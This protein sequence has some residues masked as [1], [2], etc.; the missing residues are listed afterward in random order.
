MCLM[1]SD[2]ETLK[3]C[4]VGKKS[5]LWQLDVTLR[6]YDTEQTSQSRFHQRSSGRGG[7][8]KLSVSLKNKKITFVKMN[9]PWESIVYQV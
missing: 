9:E 3:M 5:G 8:G 4:A 7:N 6:Q 1:P 2:D